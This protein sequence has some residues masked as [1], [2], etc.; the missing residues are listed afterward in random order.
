LDKDEPIERRRI[1]SLR[2]PDHDEDCIRRDKRRHKPH[3]PAPARHTGVSRQIV[4]AMRPLKLSRNTMLHLR[5]L[6]VFSHECGVVLGLSGRQGTVTIPMSR[7]L[8]SLLMFQ[9]AQRLAEV[10]APEDA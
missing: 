8:A 6:Q 2:Q 3:K 9:L 10:P 7:R 1:G 4:E 5:S